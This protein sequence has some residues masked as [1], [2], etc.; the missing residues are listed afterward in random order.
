M[1]IY[2]LG[3]VT[4]LVFEEDAGEHFDARVHAEQLERQVQREVDE[5]EA[6]VVRQREDE[7]RVQVHRQHRHLQRDTDTGGR[8]GQ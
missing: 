4:Y 3:A 6:R 5:R 7:R 1:C 2:V 8:H